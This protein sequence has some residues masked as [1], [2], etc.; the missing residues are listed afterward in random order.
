MLNSGVSGLQ[1]V[2]PKSLWK[3]GGVNSPASGQ[4][5]LVWPSLPRRNERAI[6]EEDTPVE[7]LI[8]H[9]TGDRRRHFNELGQS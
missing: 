4:N 7:H 1:G 8:H 5:S 2:L 9:E 6:L 3:C